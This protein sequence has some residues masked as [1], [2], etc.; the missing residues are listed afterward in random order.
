MANM[1]QN[2]LQYTL[3]VFNNLNIIKF[4]YITEVHH[5][6]GTMKHVYLEYACRGTQKYPIML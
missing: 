2:N 6:N 1:L 3:I 4:M 5:K